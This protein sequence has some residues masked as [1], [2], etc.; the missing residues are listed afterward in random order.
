M[1]LANTVW[2]FARAGHA[3]PELL[4]AIAVVTVPRLRDCNP[5]NLANTVWAFATAGHAAA[6]LFDAIAAEAVPRLLR[7]FNPQGLA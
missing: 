6:E 4:N 1:D 5:Q 7:D 2:A 3:A